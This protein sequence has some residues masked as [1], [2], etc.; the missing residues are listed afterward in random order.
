MSLELPILTFTEQEAG[1]NGGVEDKKLHVI[2]L[3]QRVDWKIDR[4]QSLC[5][6]LSAAY[7]APGNTLEF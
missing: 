6:G 4:K 7:N 5:H 2:C 3:L 1:K